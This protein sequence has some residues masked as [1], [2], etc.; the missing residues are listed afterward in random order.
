MR[1]PLSW[2]TLRPA[3][4]R[5]NPNPGREK[6]PVTYVSFWDAAR[7]ANWLS[8]GNAEAGFYNLGGVSEPDNGTITRDATAWANGGIAVTSENEW[9][10]AAFFSGS[11]TGADGDGYWLYATQRN[12]LT[13]AV[14][15][16]RT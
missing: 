2:F 6:R 3:K 11:P 12:C 7:F 13:I 5:T 8:T 16:V 1:V 14:N 4:Q 10:K 15:T 9:Y